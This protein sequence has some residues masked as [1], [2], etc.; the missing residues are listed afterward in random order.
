MAL[1]KSAVFTAAALL[2]AAGL[3]Y[4]VVWRWGIERVWV[5][6]GYSLQLTSM[7]GNSA[8]KEGYAQPGQQGVLQQMLGPGRHFL[9]PW[10]YS[11][12][13]VKDFEVPPG[14]I[15]LVR[16]NIGKDLPEGRFLAGP[17][18]KG[19][20][21][22]VLTP[23]VWRINDFGQT[24]YIQPDYAKAGHADSQPMTYIPPGYVG[25][26]TFAEGANKGISP[27]VLQAG[28]YALNPEQV[29]VTI[30]GI[31]Y[32]VQEMAVEYEERQVRDASGRTTR[33]KVPKEGTGVNFPL[34]D[35][36]QMYLDMT[37]V[38]GIYPAD[39]PRIVSDYGT[40]EDLE[41][42]IIVP[43]ILSICKNA[44]SDLTTKDF[45]AGNTRDQFQERVTQ[46]LQ[47]IGKEKGIHFLIALV[48]GFH[49]DPEITATIQAR[50]LAEEEIITLGIEQSR[51]TVAGELEGAKRKV[52]TALKDFDSETTALVA[53]QKEEGLKQAAMVKATADRQVAAI[54][55]QVAEIDAKAIQIDGKAE[56]DVLEHTG[57]AQA[58]LMKLM[59]GA[60]GGPDA[61]NL[62]TFAKNLPDDLKV[63]YHYAGPGTLWTDVGAGGLQDTAARKIMSNAA[64]S[65]K[66]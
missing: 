26:Q 11:R 57:R 14:H 51:D 40:E 9:T 45:I 7:T 52:A 35:G 56:A 29:K 42:K 49:P 28:Y 3:A 31:G 22:S 65:N 21:L 53:K 25:V 41:R 4:E 1:K 39:A 16:N 27:R 59:V 19:T 10:S 44:G 63:E 38:W 33:L 30:V 58:E 37:V 47:A 32:D 8:A 34:A 62:A 66:P 61:Y 36:K 6:P 54:N 2:V 55:R 24:P 20:Q 13:L 12:K 48:K 60:Y 18:E 43:Q 46:E 23:G 17:D 64:P 15:A 50:M 5:P